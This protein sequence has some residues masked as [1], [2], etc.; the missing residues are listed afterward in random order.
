MR[1]VYPAFYA[2]LSAQETLLNIYLHEVFLA[3][4]EVRIVVPEQQQ[5]IDTYIRV[6]NI[7][8][9]VFYSVLIV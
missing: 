2:P 8:P 3:V 4:P 1:R 6:K 5:K 9:C 7:H